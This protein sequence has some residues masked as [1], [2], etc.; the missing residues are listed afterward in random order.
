MAR[1][2]VR[3]AMLGLLLATAGCGDDD[4]DGPPVCTADPEAVPDVAGNYVVSE[5]SL[6]S[7]DCPSA[8]DEVIQDAL[9]R[10]DECVFAVSQDGVN[11]Q[12]VDCDDDTYTG[13]VVES[14]ETSFT[15]TRRE[16]D[17]GCTVRIDAELAA[18]LTES[19]TAG[20]LTFDIELSGSCLELDRE[21][22]AV[23]D[24]TVTRLLEEGAIA[25]VD[26]AL[27]GAAKALA[28]APH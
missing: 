27:G 12:A 3:V 6:G 2:L 14:G 20:T 21:C 17:L 19:P 11:V 7:S 18:N 24:A 28:E 5:P 26:S 4:D 16:S 15:A 25:G 1:T 9:E 10:A 8:I 13:C 23:I 22:T